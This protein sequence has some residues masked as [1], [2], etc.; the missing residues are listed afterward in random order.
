VRTGRGKPALLYEMLSNAKAC[1]ALRGGVVHNASPMGKGYTPRSGRS[2]RLLA[3]L[4]LL[5]AACSGSDATT[6]STTA[7]STTVAATTSTSTTST[8]TTTTSTTSTTSSTTTSMVPDGEGPPEIDLTAGIL[9]DFFLWWVDANEFI[10]WVQAHPTDDLGVLSM[11][12]HPDGP[13]IEEK[14]ELYR[15]YVEDGIRLLNADLGDAL[16]IGGG[17]EPQESIDGGS[18]TLKI[19]SRHPDP[20]QFVDS[21]GVV[22]NELKGWT[23]FRWRAELKRADDG[24]WLIW[25]FGAWTE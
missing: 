7:T 11:L 4:G 1:F 13:E 8:S 19:I 20:A 6:T 24:Q 5:L 21:D 18:I 17:S 25:D 10:G 3:A 23:E 22:L 9:E 15:G 14:A 12:Y 16:A 2:L